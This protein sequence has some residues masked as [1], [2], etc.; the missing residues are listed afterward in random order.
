MAT[1]VIAYPTFIGCDLM[2]AGSSI[3]TSDSAIMGVVPGDDDE[4]ITASPTS[5]TAD[6]TVTIS[7]GSNFV[8]GFVHATAGKL[9]APDFTANST[10][11]GCGGDAI[12]K[13]R[14][15]NNTPAAITW[16]PPSD[17]SGLPRVTLSVAAAKGY[18]KVFRKLTI[19]TND[20]GTE[21]TANKAIASSTK[22]AFALTFF[23]ARVCV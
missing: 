20:Q 10:K 7:F 5:Y 16:T 17:I 8:S 21:G 3:M 2:H 6:S 12:I 18:S 19:L 14:A 22:L 15:G 23:F 13:Y 11:A 1:S 9:D 4:L